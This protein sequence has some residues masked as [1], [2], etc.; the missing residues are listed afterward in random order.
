[1]V[2]N[3]EPSS[4]MLKPDYKAFVIYNLIQVA[5]GV[6]IL[7]IIA[8]FA[9]KL[10]VPLSAF[11]LLAGFIF[12]VGGS[13]IVS[14]SR[15]KKEEYYVYVDKLVHKGGGLFSDFEKEL[16]IKNITHLT[17]R[18]P[19]LDYNFFSVGFIKIESAG[20]SQ[21]EIYLKSVKQAEEL[22]KQIIE[23][24]KQNGFRLAQKNLIQEERPQSIAVFFEVFGGI[25]T[26]FFV[27]SGIAVGLAEDMKWEEIVQFITK[28]AVMLIIC[29][30]V[31]VLVIIIRAVFH[32][33]D[34]KN[35]IYELYDDAITYAEGFL[36]KNFSIIPM[37]NLSDSEITQSFIS[38]KLN[39][40]DVKLSCQ[41]S[42]QEILFKNIA[43]GE[44]LSKN[45][46]LLIAKQK[47]SL[48]N[49]KMDELLSS[50]SKD[51]TTERSVQ[52]QTQVDTE[53][54]EEFRMNSQRVW[55]P[56]LLLSPILILIFPLGIALAISN[57]INVKHNIF[58]IKANAAEHTYS[59]LSRKT[60]EFSFDKITGI[61]FKTSLFDQWLKT[62]S[63][64]FWSI[65]SGNNITFRNIDN[66]ELLVEKILSKKGIRTQRVLCT[67]K[68]SINPANFI[69]GNIGANALLFLMALATA[70]SS[71]ITWIPVIILSTIFVVL[72][73]YQKLA[74]NN[75]SLIFYEDY[76]HFAKGII[77][78][79]NYYILYDDIKDVETVK[80]PWSNYGNL[81]FNVAGETV[82]K[83]NEGN[84]IKSNTITIK[85]A[86]GISVLDEFI[87]T[88]FYKRPD[89]EE[90]KELIKQIKDTSYKPRQCFKQSLL[91]SV[92][93]VC[94]GLFF[95]D[96]ICVGS[97]YIIFMNSIPM[98]AYYSLAIV[99]VLII[100]LATISI[101]S[102][103]YNLD[104]YR[105]YTKSGIIFKKQKSIIF[106]KVDFTNSNQGLMNKIFGTGN[107]TINTTGSSN[108]ELVIRNVK[109]YKQLSAFI[110]EGIRTGEYLEN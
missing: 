84:Y 42:A 41:G 95:L 77:L 55:M 90:M 94:I 103:S 52:R 16:E 96:L 76:L 62:C 85:Y 2:E 31:V 102:I 66:S 20:S 98:L 88:I 4:R 56:T 37:E 64:L 106:N 63:V 3:N 107:I 59:F 73:V 105:I 7:L 46:D 43:N 101:K 87:D 44:K 23:V 34:L 17:M 28:N 30:G 54:E 26:A 100:V 58:K 48:I 36:N 14:D 71:E 1:M 9:I 13:F 19:F 86:K 82:I 79:E 47:D 35:R 29:I 6:G 70:F 108:P 75:Q 99:N 12:I 93:P 18:L 15:Y 68:S 33:L 65:G 22:Y 8:Y 11:Y 92:F 49:D 67:L 109:Q 32:F 61:I 25:V 74:S 80:Y 81:K 69:S 57:I 97:F 27:V 50:E 45:I 78:K 38:K 51:A 10:L 24:M 21:T 53:Y 5:I 72:C 83:T 39:L 60:T 40:Y 91:N 89:T 104:A 110:K